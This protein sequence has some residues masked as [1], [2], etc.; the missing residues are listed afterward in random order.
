MKVTNIN[1]NILKEIIQRIS[2]REKE[3]QLKRNSQ[4]MING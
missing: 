4:N 1:I 3:T 2:E